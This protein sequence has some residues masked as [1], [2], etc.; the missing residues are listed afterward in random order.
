MRDE[1]DDFFSICIEYRGE[2]PRG[3]VTA[4][5]APRHSPSFPVD[6]IN[7]RDRLMDIESLFHFAENEQSSLFL[8]ED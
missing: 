2:P 8:F 6:Y 4:I 5:V 7:L 1:I 3:I